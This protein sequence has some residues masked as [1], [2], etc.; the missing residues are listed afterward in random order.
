MSSSEAVDLGHGAEDSALCA[1]YN[2]DKHREQ[3]ALAL[4]SSHDTT[5]A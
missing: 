2:N 5:K 4:A 1:S 3:R